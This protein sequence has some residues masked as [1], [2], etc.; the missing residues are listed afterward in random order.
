MPTATRPSQQFID[1]EILDDPAIYPDEATLQKLFTVPPYDPKTQRL[2]T[3]FWTK[4]VT[5]Q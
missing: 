2:V 4:I 5:G 1:K 3:R